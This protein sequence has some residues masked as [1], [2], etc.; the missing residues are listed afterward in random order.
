[1]NLSGYRSLTSKR[2]CEEETRCKRSPSPDSAVEAC[3]HVRT[4]CIVYNLEVVLTVVKEMRGQSIDHLLG[5]SEE[6]GG[7]DHIAVQTQ[8]AVVKL[9]GRRVQVF[10]PIPSFC[11]V[12]ANLY[13]VFVLSVLE[14]PQVCVP[15][16][17]R[18][19]RLWLRKV[20]SIA[21]EQFKLRER[22]EAGTGHEL[23]ISLPD[24]L[25]VSRQT[26]G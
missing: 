15:Q 4:I 9:I 18:V 25:V 8:A 14:S 11:K 13:H 20:A 17:I 6:D 10:L 12:F 22:S 2:R 24:E 16:V 26:A 19:Q 7:N 23:S 1:M 3:L 5:I 21:L